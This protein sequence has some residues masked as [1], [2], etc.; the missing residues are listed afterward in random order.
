MHVP[1]SNVQPPLAA[2]LTG[3]GTSDVLCGSLA[4]VVDGLQRGLAPNA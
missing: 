2:A 4:T 1:P 3:L